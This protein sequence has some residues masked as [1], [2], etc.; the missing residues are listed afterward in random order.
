MRD[1]QT[2]VKVTGMGPGLAEGS[3]GMADDGREGI[4]QDMCED[5]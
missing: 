3:Q 4:D 5:D 2:G 1:R